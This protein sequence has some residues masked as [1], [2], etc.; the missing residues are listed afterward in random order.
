V[1]FSNPFRVITSGVEGEILGLLARGDRSYTS[2]EIE[3]NLNSRSYEPI[4]LALKRLEAQGILTAEPGG[5]RAVLYR[6]NGE[7]LA[8]PYVQ[9]IAL[10]RQEL[11]A[12][13]RETLDHWPIAPAAA[14]VFGSVSRGQATESS[15]LDLLVIRP[16][17]IPSED[18]GWQ[19]Q[20]ATLASLA[21]RWT[22]NDAR[23]L[24]YG[25]EEL[26][27]LAGTEPVLENAARE[28]I[29]LTTR[30]FRAVFQA[31]AKQ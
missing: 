15:D 11:I 1:D 2:R 18:A 10:L 27:D 17:E 12:R 20:V 28:G 16:K 3:R 21:T 5:A 14:A 13:L 19:D 29:D 31:A 4:R 23:V 22:G 6:F 24:E 7:H 26:S 8:A 25:I 30:S 9:G